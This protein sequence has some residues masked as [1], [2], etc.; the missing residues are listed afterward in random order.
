M[1]Y[2]DDLNLAPGNAIHGDEGGSR[3][4]QLSRPFNPADT[5]NMR[6]IGQCLDVTYDRHDS[7]ISRCR[8][9]ARN[10]VSDLIEVPGCRASPTHPHLPT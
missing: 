3:D 4:H 6:V 2:R 8:I 5:A 7:S 10:N 9:I 1:K